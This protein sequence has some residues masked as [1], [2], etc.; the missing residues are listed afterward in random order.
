MWRFCRNCFPTWVG[1]NECGIGCASKCNFIDNALEDNYH[2]FFQCPN[3]IQ[4]SQQTQLYIMI[5]FAVSRTNNTTAIFFTMMHQL[6][7]NVVASFATMLWVSGS[8]TIIYF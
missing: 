6:N 1:L 3:S 4:C 2:L 8:N 5:I 7:T